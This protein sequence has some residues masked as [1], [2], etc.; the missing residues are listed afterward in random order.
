MLGLFI[1]CLLGVLVMAMMF[2]AREAGAPESEW[3]DARQFEDSESEP[4]TVF[5]QTRQM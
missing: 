3:Q 1:G 2:M 4:A 5:P